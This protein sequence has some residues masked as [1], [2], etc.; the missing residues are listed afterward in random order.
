VYSDHVRPGDYWNGVQCQDVQRLSYPS[1]SFDA[2][3]HSEVFE[4]VPDDAAGFR[5][6]YRVIKKGGVTVF[7]VPVFDREETVERASL[8]DGEIHHLLPPSYHDD[9]LRGRVLAFRDYGRDIVDRLKAAGFS[10]VRMRSVPC[11]AGLAFER[12]GFDR[13]VITAT[14]A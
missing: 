4:H 5:E 12:R 3:V 8:V 13:P 7:T 14:K 1:D 2:C 9:Q 10:Q 6:V 11:A